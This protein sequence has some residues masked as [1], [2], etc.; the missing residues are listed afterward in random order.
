ML[1]SALSNWT[2]VRRSV[3]IVHSSGCRGCGANGRQL[4]QRRGTRIQRRIT[5][6]TVRGRQNGGRVGHTCGFKQGQEP[7]FCYGCSSR[8]IGVV[9]LLE[10]QTL[11][12]LT[13]QSQSRRHRLIGVVSNETND[14]FYL[15][16]PLGLST[17]VVNCIGQKDKRA[18]W[19]RCGRRKWKGR[20]FQYF[21]SIGV[22]E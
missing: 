13:R 18:Q 12:P 1:S 14:V 20:V 10:K 6:D 3:F 2:V 22:G 11:D 19:G 7:L 9:L 15:N 5:R 21:R 16:L 17:L 8:C 4:Q